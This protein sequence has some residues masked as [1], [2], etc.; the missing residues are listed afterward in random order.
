MTKNERRVVKLAAELLAD[1]K[2]M[3]IAEAVRQVKAFW[4]SI[5]INSANCYPELIRRFPFHQGPY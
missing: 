5:V 1:D 4:P 3:S 2:T